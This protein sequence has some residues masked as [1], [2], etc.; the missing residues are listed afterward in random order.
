MAVFIAVLMVFTVMVFKNVEAALPVDVNKKCHLEISLSSSNYVEDLSKSN[1]DVELYRVASIS[2]AGNYTGLGA[3]KKIDWSTVKYDAS[4]SAKTWKERAKEASKEIK[5]EKPVYT[6]TLKNGNVQINDLNTG[7]Y[8]VV[9]KDNESDYYSYEFTPYLVSL[10]NNYYYSTGDDTWYYDLTGMRA[11]GIK[12]SRTPRMS[13][14]RITKTL[15]NL[16]TTLSSK[17]TFVYQVD[18]ESLEGEKETRF[19]TMNF[20]VATE[21]SIVVSSI[22]AGSKV[23]V[24]EVYS[25][26]GYEIV[27]S[28]KVELGPISVSDSLAQ[29]RFVNRANDE[30]QGGYGIVNNYKYSDENQDYEV[31]QIE[32]NVSQE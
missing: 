30:I 32:E 5:N 12:A 3:F 9:I 13:A 2:Q 18:I 19:I 4:Q 1:I 16:N 23:T 21:K 17:A 11:V 22:P 31:S 29:A 10:P 14:I 6:T 27:G 24:E 28:S 15:T 26:A 7:L 20:D 8:L 25:G